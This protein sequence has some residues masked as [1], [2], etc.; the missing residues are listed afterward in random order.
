[1][2]KVNALQLRQS[3][4]KILRKL[5]KTGEPILVE[6]NREP[7]AVLVTVK[8]FKERYLDLPRP[9]L[10]ERTRIVERIDELAKRVAPE[11]EPTIP[12][13]N[14]IVTLIRQMRGPLR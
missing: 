2:Q 6:K 9:S 5:E 1:M 11:I 12:G 13:V 10:E 7:K 3:L 8:D 14:D 4:G